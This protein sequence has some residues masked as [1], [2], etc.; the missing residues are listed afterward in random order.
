VQLAGAQIRS[1]PMLPPGTPTEVTP[2]GVI[3]QQGPTKPVSALPIPPVAKIG[4]H[5][6]GR[7]Q[8]TYVDPKWVPNPNK[9][10]EQP[11][12]ITADK[13]WWSGEFVIDG[14]ELFQAFSKAFDVKK[15]EAVYPDATPFFQTSLVD[16]QL[17]RQEI[18]AGNKVVKEEVVKPLA[19]QPVT[20]RPPFPA[21]DADQAVFN[22]Y[23]NVVTQNPI[24]LQS[25]PF[26]E[27][28]AGDPWMEPG[29]ATDLVLT[30]LKEANKETRKQLK[31]QKRLE[32]QQRQASAAAARGAR[33][34][35]RG[36]GNAP[37]SD[38]VGD[39]MEMPENPGIRMPPPRVATP[40]PARPGARALPG[41]PGARQTVPVT[42]VVLGPGKFAVTD[43]LGPIRI[44]AHDDTVEP[45]KR[46][47]YKLRY[48]L[49]NPIYRGTAAAPELT[50]VFSLDAK[51]SAWT[52]TYT[53]RPKVEFFLA[54]AGKNG[55]VFDTFTFKD[56]VMKKNSTSTLQPGDAVGGTGWSL[57]DAGGSGDKAYA[58]LMDDL[59]LVVR[60]EPRADKESDRYEELLFEAA[61]P[62]VAV[63]Q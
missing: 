61:Q 14:A 17:V 51:D 49:F 36:V 18:G 1:A 9:P 6:E 29:E 13:D 43:V 56:G 7:S 31:E 19:N 30:Q 32:A 27:V 21:P 57:V 25:P 16:V 50:K 20:V 60:R 23:L 47:R 2:E 58:L 34:G 42:P 24:E 52:S 46:Y 38:E 28:L 8:V 3:V 44:I 40:A 54:S 45:G 26:Y 22:T 37:L 62:P 33:V 55:A 35:V 41:R 5:T 48:K 15:I 4:S 63:N 53:I 10:N 12:M 59:G 11:V 39:M